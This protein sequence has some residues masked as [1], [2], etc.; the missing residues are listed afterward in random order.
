LGFE[1]YDLLKAIYGVH[2]AIRRDTA[3]RTDD[4]LAPG[5]GHRGLERPG[6]GRTIARGKPR[7]A[8]SSKIRLRVDMKLGFFG[9]TT[10]ICM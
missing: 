7:A 5:T 10:D 2:V 1:I 4:D 9:Q 8:A 6:Q 3:T